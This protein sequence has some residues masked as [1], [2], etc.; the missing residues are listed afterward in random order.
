MDENK[1]KNNQLFSFG[2]T[3]VSNLLIGAQLDGQLIQ[4]IPEGAESWIFIHDELT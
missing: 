4:I 1:M 2:T 3:D